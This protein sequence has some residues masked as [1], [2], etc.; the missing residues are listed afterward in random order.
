MKQDAGIA[1]YTSTNSWVESLKR[2]KPD[3]TA[4]FIP[5]AE[6]F[7][8]EHSNTHLRGIDCR[9]QS[10]RERFDQVTKIMK[11]QFTDRSMKHMSFYGH[12]WPIGMQH[13][14]TM[15]NIPELA[16][17]IARKASDHC[18]IYFN[19]CSMARWKNAVKW[20]DF[21]PENLPSYVH[22]CYTDIL[23]KQI[24]LD[25]NAAGKDIRIY[26]H[27]TRGH[28]TKNPYVVEFAKPQQK[29][30]PYI[31]WVVNPWTWKTAKQ[32]K[33]VGYSDHGKTRW[34]AW[35]KVLKKNDIRT[36]IGLF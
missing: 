34:K 2:F 24:M 14:L 7:K 18:H 19:C 29:N 4:V 8:R 16:Q 6:K 23:F 10:M 25:K 28:A 21:I 9:A 1:F 30:D 27:Y 31:S 11:W 26:A 22:G 35:I 20:P 12:G 17:L 32:M 5:E 33:A 3:A 15:R 13:G 36:A